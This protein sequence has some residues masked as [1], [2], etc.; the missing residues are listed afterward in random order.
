M[1][2]FFVPF[3]SHAEEKKTAA[4]FYAEWC[5]HCQKVDRYFEK[6]GFYER[7]DIVK[8][9][10]DK[11][12][13]KALLGKVIK[14]KSDQGAGIPAIVIDDG[15]LLGDKSIIDEFESKI[16]SSSG[17]T[18]ESLDQFGAGI[19]DEQK[20][21]EGQGVALPL[22]FSAALS[23]AI[24][25]CAFAVLIILVGTILKSQGKKRA[26][27]SGLL[28]SSAIFISYFLM[29]LGLYKAVTI[30]NIPKY[31]SLAIG[32]LAIF[33]GLANI[34]DVFWPGKFFIME[35]PMSWRPKMKEI[36]MNVTSPLGAFISG[37]LVSLFLLP[38]SSGPY[39]VIV[40]L[41]AERV[42]F[43]ATML[44]LLLYNLIFILP[45][46][47]ITSGVY[48]FNVRLGDLEKMRVENLRLL[49]AIVGVIMLLMGLYLING[50]A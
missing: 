7:Y 19:P 38:C 36:L 41:L 31:F 32:V 24:N 17:T 9:N 40:G 25:P 49:H 50:W 8:Y 13:N 3:I 34:K 23:D 26:L 39:V 33:I 47:L 45:M 10:F 14:A 30:F 37:L 46:V 2:A 20:Q 18:M 28:F 42:N 48:F 22:I 11:P 6:E 15:L 5:S 35:V 1:L 12:E 21:P 44:Q 43:S 16:E 27:W 4:Y 29:G